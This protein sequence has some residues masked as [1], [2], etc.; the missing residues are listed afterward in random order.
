MRR[1]LTL[2]MAVLAVG[3]LAACGDAGA[4]N[5]YIDQVNKLQSAA[6]T[7]LTAL[8]TSASSGD[9]AAAADSLNQLADRADKLATDIEAL[10]APEDFTDG[11]A[12]LIKSL[13][14][15]ATTAR[16]ASTAIAAGDVQAGI[17]AMGK[18]TELDTA[19]AA[20]IQQIND[21]R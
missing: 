5:D 16:E 4:K 6:Q 3:V 13:K 17:T 12:A 18:M 14:D 1:I 21:A 8:Q 15:M 2:L 10:D 20:A 11:D 7:D 9:P 19:M